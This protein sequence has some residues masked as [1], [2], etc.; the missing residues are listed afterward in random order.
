MA[1]SWSGRGRHLP[2][3]S[4]TGSALLVVVVRRRH[5]T[6]ATERRPRTVIAGGGAGESF[7]QRIPSED[8]SLRNLYRVIVTQSHDLVILGAP[9]ETALR[10]LRP[11]V[12]RDPEG[13][14][15]VSDKEIFEELRSIYAHLL[16]VDPATLTMDT[17]LRRDLE[18]DS[19]DL[20][21]VARAA[22][23]RFGCSLDFDLAI[24]LRTVA[25]AV[26][27]VRAAAD[28]DLPVRAG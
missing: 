10:R 13:R 17:D 5:R 19:L 2:K 28:R 1:T 20:A 24:R 8:V 12:S 4:S 7:D 22:E 9:Q 27:L 14:P 3:A 23:E 15:L 21:E 25:D 6:D 11:P 18:V 26:A 16:A